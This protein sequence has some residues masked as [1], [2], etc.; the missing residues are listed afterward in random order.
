MLKWTNEFIRNFFIHEIFLIFFKRTSCCHVMM[1]TSALFPTAFI[2]NFFIV[3][4]T[5]YDGCIPGLW[6]TFE[7]RKKDGKIFK[8]NSERKMIEKGQWR[9]E[10]CIFKGVFMHRCQS[11]AFDWLWIGW[12]IDWSNVFHIGTNSKIGTALSPIWCKFNNVWPA[13]WCYRSTVN[14]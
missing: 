6:L 12:G 9:M 4:I 11:S 14:I 8:K 1:M 10:V 7:N 2:F 13:A 3:Y 5:F